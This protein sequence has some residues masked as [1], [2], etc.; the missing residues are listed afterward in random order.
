MSDIVVKET[1]KLVHTTRLDFQRR[2]EEL[3]GNIQK[4]NHDI[5]DLENK[6]LVKDLRDKQ[7]YG[8]LHYKYATHHVHS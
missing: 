3:Q 1:E 7:Q 5:K 2:F 6:L 8:H 4:L